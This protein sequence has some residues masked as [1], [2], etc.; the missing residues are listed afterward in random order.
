MRKLLVLGA[1]A[2]QLP[3]IRLAKEM[4][5]YVG[6]ADYN[7][8][9]VGISYAD[10]FFC[11]STI[12]VEAVCRL[13]KEFRPDGIMT[14][15]TDM[16]MRSIAAATALLG[17][18]GISVDTAFRSTDKLEMIKTFKQKGVE[19]PW[20]IYL[21]DENDFRLH[22]GKIQCPCVIKPTDNAGSR[23]VVLVRKPTELEEAYEYSRSQSR[24][25][26]VLVEEYMEGPE[27]SVE[28]VVYKGVPHVLVVTDKLTTGEPYFVEMGHSQPSLLP[29]ADLERIEDL[30]KRAVLS[31]GIEDGPAH[32]EIKLT[33]EGP[34]MVELG[35]R[36][37]GDCISTHLVP[38]ATGIDMLK[39]TIDIALG[40]RPD[41]EQTIH[42][43][44]A[45]RFIGGGFDRITAIDG[46]EEAMRQPH[47]KWV[48]LFKSPGDEATEIHSSL[49]RVACVV[50]QAD[51]VVEAVASCEFALEKI[52]VS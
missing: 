48:Q 30:A 14:L 41:L 33:P 10:A 18:P 5:L 4:G 17:L 1:S 36:M 27:V 50:T 46:V 49:D 7:P 25:G 38:L 2:L 22:R 9:A 6:V 28:V 13:A 11:V 3:A 35:A 31:V 34:K 29:A 21:S 16:P 43:C 24:A 44:S 42:K 37:G 20:Y 40:N 15:A 23:G 45:V 19:S 51:S 52:V 8:K 12:D 32:V 26:H 39:A 47:V